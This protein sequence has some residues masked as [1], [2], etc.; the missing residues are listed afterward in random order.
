MQRFGID[1]DN[2]SPDP[3]RIEKARLLAALDELHR[4]AAPGSAAQRSLIPPLQ[5]GEAGVAASIAHCWPNDGASG[6]GYRAGVGMGLSRG[7]KPQTHSYR[8]TAGFAQPAGFGGAGRCPANSRLRPLEGKGPRSDRMGFVRHQ[9]RH[10][11]GGACST[12][13][14]EAIPTACEAPLSFLLLERTR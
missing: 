8:S 12:A 3:K 4:A 13:P 1:P 11:A 7:T 6:A 5:G 9:S 2:M 10:S 14:S